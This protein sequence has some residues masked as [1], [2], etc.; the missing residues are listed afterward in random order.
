VATILVLA[1]YAVPYGLRV[2]TLAARGRPVPRW[3]LWCF[4]TGLAILAVVSTAPADDLAHSRFVGHM[5]EHLLIADAASL[6]LVLG[7]SGPILAPLL[8]LPVLDR[9]R[10]LTH[11]VVAFSLWALNLYLWHLAD[12]YEA[13][14]R[15]DAVHALEHACFLF[16]G[17][18]LWMPLFG[19]LPK[20]AWF[21][22]GA[23]LFYIVAVRLT[24]SVLANVFLWSDTLFYPS[25]GH[26]SDQSAAGAVMMVEES[27]TTILLFGW[28]FA[29][30]MREGDERQALEELAAARGVELE[31]G[32]AARAVAAGRG[33][34]LRR[35]LLAD[36]PPQ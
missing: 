26:L 14:L 15:H 28:L 18:L 9:V 7:L 5:A 17:V 4:G 25:Y 36:G 2:R 33:D 1:A 8:R 11:P 32:R 12:A 3:R 21:G 6:L 31:P 19:P 20:P 23:Q 27:L 35:R 16:A 22:L 29:K 34:E 30:W 10:W 24:G 13:A